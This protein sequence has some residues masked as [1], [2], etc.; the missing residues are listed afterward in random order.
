[1]N[2]QGSP[3]IKHAIY[4]N[5]APVLWCRCRTNKTVI[6]SLTVIYLSSYL[7]LLW[8]D[9]LWSFGLS[10][11]LFFWHIKKVYV[12]V[13]LC[14]C[15]YTHISCK[16]TIL[17]R[18][19]SI[20]SSKCWFENVPFLAKVSNEFCCIW[21]F[22]ICFISQALICKTNMDSEN[23]DLVLCPFVQIPPH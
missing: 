15:V 1:M 6:S 19:F 7:M 12:R 20:F 3:D 23:W 8:V 2:L 14:V 18:H 17:Q 11:V 16:F 22:F 9:P 10:L 4:M 5:L 13:C 21:F